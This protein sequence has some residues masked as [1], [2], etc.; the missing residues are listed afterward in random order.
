[1]IVVRP[2]FVTTGCGTAGRVGGLFLFRPHALRKYSRCNTLLGPAHC[3]EIKSGKVCESAL[4]VIKSAADLGL[5]VDYAKVAWSE[6]GKQTVI[7]DE[8]I[9]GWKW[10]SLAQAWGGFVWRC[11][12]RSENEFGMTH[13]AVA[14]HDLLNLYLAMFCSQIV[15]WSR[16]V[17]DRWDANAEIS[18]ACYVCRSI[19][20]K[21]SEWIN[22][23]NVYF[24]RRIKNVFF[25]SHQLP[26]K[27][28]S[29][30]VEPSVFVDAGRLPKN[31]PTS[32]PK[33]VLVMPPLLHEYGA[34]S[35]VPPGMQVSEIPPNWT[36]IPTEKHHFLKKIQ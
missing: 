24:K 3:A 26:P 17:A 13:I 33:T 7:L 10:F 32:I 8:P 36:N 35:I 30:V 19:F 29:V 1:M 14:L 18:K 5:N 20:L 23:R 28:I 15:S 22:I 34:T 31:L 11:S 4:D 21:K 27:K 16:I 2:F 6:P 9:G 25:W 12:Q